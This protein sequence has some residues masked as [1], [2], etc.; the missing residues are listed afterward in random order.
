MK[1]LTK[2]RYEVEEEFTERKLV[3]PMERWRNYLAGKGPSPDVHYIINL[4]DGKAMDRSYWI[5]EEPLDW[6]ITLKKMNAGECK[7]MATLEG[8]N[9]EDVHFYAH[10]GYFYSSEIRLDADEVKLLVEHEREESREDKLRKYVDRVKARAEAEGGTRAPIKEDVQVFVWNRDGG[11]C[12]TC[13][14]NEALE[15]DHIIPVS[16]MVNKHVILFMLKTLLM[17]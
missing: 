2:Y 14:G 8:E 10:N 5:R 15:F 9:G 16:K 3:K 7:Y 17:Y 4:F 12:V 6:A 1:I 13:G 11:K